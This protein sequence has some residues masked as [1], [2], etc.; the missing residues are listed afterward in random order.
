MQFFIFESVAKKET[1]ASDI[2]LLVISDTL[3]YADLLNQLSGTEVRRLQHLGRVSNATIYT[4]GDV[5]QR[6]QSGHAFL[7]RILEKPKIWIIGNESDLP[8]S[9]SITETYSS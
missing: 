9:P 7:S 2:D 5:Q 3:S 6:L 8:P 1:V 4:V